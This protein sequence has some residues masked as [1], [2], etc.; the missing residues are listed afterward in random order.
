M[1]PLWGLSQQGFRKV[2]PDRWVFANEGFLRGQ[3][4]LL[5]TITR[6]KPAHGHPQNQ[7]QPNGQNSSV[8]ACVEVGKFGLE[9]EVERLKRD[10]NV[11]MQELVR[12]RQQQQSTDNQLQTMV[13]RLQGMEQR[14]QQMMSFLA[15]A[16]NSPGFLAQF[17]QQ[18]NDTNQRMMQT[19]KKRRLKQEDGI[20]EDNSSDGQIVKYQPK[21]NEAAQAMLRQIIKM[22]SSPRLE[23]FE[24]SP[25]SFL[26]SDGECGSSVKHASGV[27]LQDV[28]PIHGPTF[29]PS[30]SQSPSIGTSNIQLPGGSPV[31]RGETLPLP[32][33]IIPELSQMVPDSNAGTVGPEAVNDILLDPASMTGESSKIPFDLDWD[34]NLLDE[35]I[36]DLPDATDPFWEKFLESPPPGDLEMH[37]NLSDDLLEGNETKGT[38]ENGWNKT[39][40][41]AELTEQMGLLSSDVKKV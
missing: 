13:E 23:N 15:K 7:Q 34:S 26:I 1:L 29:V 25:D 22:N 11:L 2:D 5:K 6:R 20:P 32:D 4:H 17:M 19:N 27:T 40:N 28:T 16:V 14:Q 30:E 38:E 18:P 41:V 24:N 21:M 10:K 33:A 8:G 37:L 35:D 12:L 39:Q 9:E 3:R 31:I 36:S